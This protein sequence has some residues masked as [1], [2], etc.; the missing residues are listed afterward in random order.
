[1]VSESLA[2]NL[3]TRQEDKTNIQSSQKIKY[4]TVLAR[5]NDIGVVEYR[6]SEGLGLQV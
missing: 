6:N 4:K 1:M 2:L 5:A 3:L